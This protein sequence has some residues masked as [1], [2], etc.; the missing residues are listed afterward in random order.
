MLWC[1]IFYLIFLSFSE[2][3]TGGITL[4]LLVSPSYTGDTWIRI[5]ATT[6]MINDWYLSWGRFDWSVLNSLL[7]ADGGQIRSGALLVIKYTELWSFNDLWCLVSLTLRCSW[8]ILCLQSFRI[9]DQ[10]YLLSCFPIHFWMTRRSGNF[11]SNHTSFGDLS[12][13][14]VSD[15]SSMVVIA[16]AS[17]EWCLS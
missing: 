12:L 14:W 3:C 15:W 5:V 10:S 6:I 11:K 13:G 9:F 8:F 17:L 2:W 16:W 1:R 4:L 7:S